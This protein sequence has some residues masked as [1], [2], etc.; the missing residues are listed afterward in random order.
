MKLPLTAGD[1]LMGEISSSSSALAAALAPCWALLGAGLLL[2]LLAAALFS[3][4]AGD[5]AA[6]DSL[7]LGLLL[8]PL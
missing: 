1:M 4:F 8:A 7:L 3:D 5:A 2:A 6:V